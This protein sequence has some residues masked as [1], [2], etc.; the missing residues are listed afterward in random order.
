MITRRGN[1]SLSSQRSSKEEGLPS[2][3]S[4]RVIAL[5][6]AAVHLAT[7][8]RFLR[9]QGSRL[10]S[11]L[12]PGDPRLLIAQVE[13]MVR[14]E[15]AFLQNIASIKTTLARYQK[16]ATAASDHTILKILS[17]ALKIM[18]VAFV[19]TCVGLLLN[20]EFGHFLLLGLYI[21]I[22]D[23]IIVWVWLRMEWWANWISGIF[24]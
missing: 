20:H 14:V 5:E 18:T 13:D 22:I 15:K 17:Q 10:Q 21:C 3:S 9:E 4:T 6:G 1:N 19:V 7:M 16:D 12:E 8:D 24:I 11:V 23:P 2:L